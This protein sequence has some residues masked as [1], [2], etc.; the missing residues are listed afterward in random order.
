MTDGDPIACPPDPIQE[1][2]EERARRTE[3]S[4]VRWRMIAAERRAVWQAEQARLHEERQAWRAQMRQRTLVALAGLAAVAL[5]VTVWWWP[6]PTGRPELAAATPLGAPVAALDLPERIPPPVVSSASEAPAEPPAPAVPE[7]AV[8]EPAVPEPVVPVTAGTVRTW[9]Q[10]DHAWIEFGIDTAEP[11][12]MRWRDA[13]GEVALSDMLC[14][15]A[16]ARGHQCRAG[17][18]QLRIEQ[19]V[20]D[21]AAPGTWTVDVCTERGCTEV[22]A[23]ETEDTP[24]IQS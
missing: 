1:A 6:E 20:A 8:P 4:L 13:H 15:R 17:R 2:N 7:P 14:F 24:G 16:T 11:A 10:G 23:F 3:A 9:R 18:S 22:S 19:A 5:L 12:W 21:G